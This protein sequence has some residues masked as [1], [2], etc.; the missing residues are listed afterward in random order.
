MRV[1]AAL[2]LGFLDH[3]ANYTSRLDV[4]SNSLKNDSVPMDG[5]GGT[6]H[7]FVNGNLARV[8]MATWRV[9]NQ[10]DG[11]TP[12]PEYLQQGLGWCDTLTEL[13]ADITSSRGNAAG[14]WGVGY[15]GPAG[16]TPPLKGECAHGGS[17]YF[18]D[19]GTAVTALALCYRLASGNTSRESAYLTAMEKFAVFVLEGS[20]TAPVNKKGFVETFVNTTTGAVGCGYYGCTD[21]TSEDCDR[22]AGPAGLSCPSR[23]PYTIATGTTGGAFFA[24]LYAITKNETYASI[25]NNAMD[26]EVSVMLASGEVPYILDG[27]NCTSKSTE[28]ECSGVGVW[29]FDTLAYV[30]EGL[31]AV[32]LHLAN[33]SA[34]KQQMLKKHMIKQWKPS[35]DYLLRTQN[36]HGYWG[37]LGSGDQMRS[38]RVLTMLSWWVW[39]VDTPTYT[40]KPVHAAIDA[41][42]TFLQGT[43]AQ[44]Y[45]LMDNTITTG[46]VGVAVADAIVFGASFGVEL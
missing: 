16:C 7:I 31:A 12:N 18:G 8:M 25:A 35:V 19:T 23:S 11:T 30:T 40:D 6:D 42:L 20:S 24:E 5:A 46:M 27:A 10:M 43:G 1:G 21:R 28:K 2:L 4:P 32:A 3:V 22:V 15:G 44:G 9:Q 34:A 26:Y 14:Y 36:A 13:Q 37:T 39:A 29:P 17:I 33:S 41:Y 45:G 38:P